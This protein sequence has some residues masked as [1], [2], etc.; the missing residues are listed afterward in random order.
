[1]REFKINDYIEWADERV[2]LQVEF[3][4]KC[5]LYGLNYVISSKIKIEWGWWGNGEE[6]GRCGQ[7]WMRVEGEVDGSWMGCDSGG[8][9]FWSIR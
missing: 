2:E 7:W 5:G 8:L 1:M 6:S 3:C 9:E 4:E